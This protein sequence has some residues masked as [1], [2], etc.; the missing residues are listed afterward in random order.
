MN[1]LVQ[2]VISAHAC[3]LEIA[4]ACSYLVLAGAASVADVA[5]GLAAFVSAA[6]AFFAVCFALVCLATAFG[7]AVAA[8][9]VV[10]AGAAAGAAGAPV[11]ANTGSVRVENR[12][13]TMMDFE[14]MA[15]FLKEKFFSLGVCLI[16]LFAAPYFH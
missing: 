12:A 9:G 5:V 2:A 16:S 3:L 14:F 11:W 10:A 13:A 6:L 1:F 8:A 15:I 7:A 4:Y